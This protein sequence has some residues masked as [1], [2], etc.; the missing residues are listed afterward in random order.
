MNRELHRYLDGEIPRDALPADL[1][2]AADVWD[3]VLGE[4]GALAETT[5]PPWLE[6]RVMAALPPASPRPLGA[7]VLQWLLEPQQIRV[8]PMVALAGA[9]AALVLMLRP[10]VGAI[11]QPKQPVPG[12]IEVVRTTAAGEPVVYVQF[13]LAADDARTVA[14][15]GDFNGWDPAGHTLRDPDGDGQWTGMFALRPGLHKYMFLVDGERWVTDPRAESYVDDGFGM[16]NALLNV[17][18]PAGRAS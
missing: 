14:V 9:A 5:A 18:A 13:V 16:R 3:E 1:R 6:E 15:A 2:A 10:P 17:A 7:R 8:R 11:E 4:L 12:E